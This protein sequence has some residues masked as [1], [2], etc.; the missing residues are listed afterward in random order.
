LSLPHGGHREYAIHVKVFE[1]YI[2]DNVASWFNWSRDRGLPV[3]RMEDLVLVYGYTLVN[4]WAAAAFDDHA[5]DAQISLTSRMLNNGGASFHWSNI[6]GI[7][8]YH[9]SQ[10]D[11]VSSPLATFTRHALIFTFFFFVVLKE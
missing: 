6:R 5:A 9:D 3:E 10:L 7:V 11:P 1:K 2:K 4:S 8:E